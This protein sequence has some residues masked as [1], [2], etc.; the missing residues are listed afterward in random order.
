MYDKLLYEA[1]GYSLNETDERLRSLERAWESSRSWEDA[2]NYVGN[3]RDI[4]KRARVMVD[5]IRYFGPLHMNRLMQ[6]VNNGALRNTDYRLVTSSDS[7][8]T[9]ISDRVNY[10]SWLVRDGGNP[11]DFLGA[12]T[13]SYMY[14]NPGEVVWYPFIGAIPGKNLR[15]SLHKDIERYIKT[16]F[17][18][19]ELRKLR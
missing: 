18:T 9:M 12:L 2:V 17:P 4:Q 16:N 13:V 8:R 3:I 1:Y 11:N 5:L 6:V 14:D 7:T 15:D 19:W 10:S